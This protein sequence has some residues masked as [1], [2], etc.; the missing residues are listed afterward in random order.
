MALTRPGVMMGTPEYMA[1]EQAYSA[2]TVDARADIYSVGAML[3]EMLCG[4][5]LRRATTHNR[6]RRS[7]SRG[8]F[9]FGD[10]LGNFVSATSA[11]TRTRFSATRSKSNESSGLR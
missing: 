3:Y 7:C 10:V 5:A 8:S 9:I 4:G 1:P 11:S 6:S 2:D